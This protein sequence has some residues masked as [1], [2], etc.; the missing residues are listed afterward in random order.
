M[1]LFLWLIE[2]GR[3]GSD[4][5]GL[6]VHPY[7]NADR[8]TCVV[9]YIAGWADAALAVFTLFFAV[10]AMRR[11]SAGQQPKPFT[12]RR[13]GFL[14]MLWAFL[15]PLWMWFEYWGLF[16]ATPSS[17]VE[18]F[19]QFRYNQLLV[20]AIWLGILAFASLVLYRSTKGTVLS[21]ISPE[22]IATEMGAPEPNRYVVTTFKSGVNVPKDG[23]EVWSGKSGPPT[24]QLPARYP[25]LAH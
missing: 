12:K 3:C 5:V 17:G 21:Q 10:A 20:T 15:P 24:C 6:P 14:T 19:G 9:I 23:K 22:A 4:T 18:G 8:I 11:L 7:A 25:A 2:G 1:D 13:L 16:M